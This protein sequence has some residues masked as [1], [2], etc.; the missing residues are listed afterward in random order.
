MVKLA[1]AL[2]QSGKWMEQ[3]S[4]SAPFRKAAVLW[5]MEVMD[6]NVQTDTEHEKN[7]PQEIVGN[8]TMS[9]MD[10]F[11]IAVGSVIFGAVTPFQLAAR[12]SL[13]YG[14]AALTSMGKPPPPEI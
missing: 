11:S 4:A 3:K 1:H 8:Y 6:R 12:Y 5:W 2:Y 13:K 10:G 14:G 7:H 9:A